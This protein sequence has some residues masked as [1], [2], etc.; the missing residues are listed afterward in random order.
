MSALPDCRL[1][2]LQTSM[3][4]A[5]SP[6][7]RAHIHTLWFL[8]ILSWACT[9][10]L[11]YIASQLPTF[12][13][14]SHTLLDSSWTYCL[15]ESLLRWDSFHFSHIAQH[16]YVYEKEWAF[17]PDMPLVMRACA[18][19]FRLLGVGSSSGDD[20]FNLEQV[21]LGGFLAACLSGSVITMYRLTLHHMRSPTLAFLAA[22]LSLLPSSPATL[23]LA[24]YSEPF[25][26]YMTYKGELS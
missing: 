11:A 17:F 2:F 22:L 4:S 21:L 10:G 18:S 3:S 15:V 25:F 12:D 23:R 24:G 9:A 19:L 5:V 14:S 26:T 16:E 1:W 13:S 20:S 7:N 8:S 6:E